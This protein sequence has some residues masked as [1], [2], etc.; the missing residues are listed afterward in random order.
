MQCHQCAGRL[1]VFAF[2]RPNM[3]LQHRHTVNPLVA[4][5]IC[6]SPL[7]PRSCGHQEPDPDLLGYVLRVGV[8]YFGAH[9][10]LANSSGTLKSK[11]YPSSDQNMVLGWYQV[12]WCAMTQNESATRNPCSAHHLPTWRPEALLSFCCMSNGSRQSWGPTSAL[13]RWLSMGP[14]QTPRRNS[15]RASFAVV[16]SASCGRNAGQVP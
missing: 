2:F 8:D 9:L 15:S 7:P 4:W 1:R 13:G 10:R 14:L 12:T 3:S 6:R 16:R 5:R 11:M